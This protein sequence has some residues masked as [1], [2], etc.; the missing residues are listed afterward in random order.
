[1]DSSNLAM[2]FAPNL[3]RCRSDDPKII[4]ENTRKEMNFI[5]AL[6]TNMDASAGAY[7]I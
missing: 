7:V 6:I 4:L 3:L 1:M 5:R 2:V